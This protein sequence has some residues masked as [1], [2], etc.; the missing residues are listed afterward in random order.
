MRGFILLISFVAPGLVMCGAQ[1]KACN[2]PYEVGLVS[3][4]WTETLRPIPPA[5][6]KK[7]LKRMG[8]A[9][10]QVRFQ[11]DQFVRANFDHYVTK[12]FFYTVEGFAKFVDRCESFCGTS[13]E[14]SQ[15]YLDRLNAMDPRQKPGK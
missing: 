8:K 10:D 7:E 9:S 14:R 3:T 11:C 5:A 12:E 15:F 2:R 1:E 6:T 4:T 13:A